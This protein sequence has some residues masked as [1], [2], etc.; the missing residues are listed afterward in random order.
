MS[1]LERMSASKA[2]HDMKAVEA[3]V[4]K[5]GFGNT[6][7]AA[8][9]KRTPATSKV[10]AGAPSSKKPR[11]TFIIKTEPVAAQPEGPPL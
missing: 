2:A 7:V 6:V 5:I 10:G 3:I 9:S 11:G 8:A 1:L 4:N